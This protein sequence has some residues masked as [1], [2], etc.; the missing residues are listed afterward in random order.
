MLSPGV[1]VDPGAIVRD[2]IVMFD[3]VIRAGAVVDRAILDKEVVVGPNAIVGMGTDYDTPNKQE[4]GAAQHG[5]HASSAS[6][7]SSRPACALAATSR[8]PS[9]RARPTSARASRSRAAARSRPRATAGR[10]AAGARKADGEPMTPSGWR[11]LFRR[12]ASGADQGVTFP[13]NCVRLSQCLGRRCCGRSDPAAQAEPSAALPERQ[14]A[15]RR[16]LRI[17]EIHEP[18]PLRASLPDGQ[19][20]SALFGVARADGLVR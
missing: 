10:Q 2:S 1:R 16:E 14:R 5:H 11:S 18:P 3:A 17:G 8:L 4:P 9:A 6:A 12:P 7:P 13:A 20:A 15:C 19:F